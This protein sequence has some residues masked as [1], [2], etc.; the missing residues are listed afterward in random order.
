MDSRIRNLTQTR[1]KTTLQRAVLF[2]ERLKTEVIS[3]TALKKLLNRAR[4]LRNRSKQSGERAF[5][6]RNDRLAQLPIW[7]LKFIPRPSFFPHGERIYQRRHVVAE[8]KTAQFFRRTEIIRAR[9]RGSLKL[10]CKEGLIDD[11]RKLRS[12]AMVRV[13]VCVHIVISSPCMRF[14]L[15]RLSSFADPKPGNIERRLR[16]R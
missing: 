7:K 4:A 6:S 10:A 5:T 8:V 1:V 2:R 13:C 9:A 12:C 11:I 16:R 15:S 3:T 14:S